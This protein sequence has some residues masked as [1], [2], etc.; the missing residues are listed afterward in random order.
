MM[1]PIVKMP[2]ETYKQAGDEEKAINVA[3]LFPGGA[4]VFET[5]GEVIMLPLIRL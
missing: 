5:K 2:V 4:M 1:V 3:N